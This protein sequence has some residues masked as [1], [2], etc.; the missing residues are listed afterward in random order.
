MS[1]PRSSETY[2]NA[3]KAK[4][5]TSRLVDSNDPEDINKSILDLLDKINQI[6][7]NIEL[8]TNNGDTNNINNIIA[9]EAQIANQARY[10]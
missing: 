7:P 9:K 3:T 2:Q 1:A 10:S 4:F 5:E 6:A 8:I